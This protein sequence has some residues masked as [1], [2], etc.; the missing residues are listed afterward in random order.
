MLGDVRLSSES[1]VKIADEWSYTEFTVSGETT[2][3]EE[4]ILQSI[5][6]FAVERPPENR[7][8]SLL[9][10]QRSGWENSSEELLLIELKT[11]LVVSSNE[12]RE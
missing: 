4:A 3:A 2:V 9:E 12:S 7:K 5:V 10:K 8:L 11:A 6:E 1:E